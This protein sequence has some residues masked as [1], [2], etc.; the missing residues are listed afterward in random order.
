MI[1]FVFPISLFIV[2]IY[3]YSLRIP[4]TL[5]EKVTT[6]LTSSRMILRG[7]GQT[8]RARL[9]RRVDI[10]AARDISPATARE[11]SARARDRDRDPFEGRTSS[12]A[13]VRGIAGSGERAQNLGANLV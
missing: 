3:S 8:G 9:A 13:L 12:G 4:R 2:T 1:L 7:V 6:L 5:S 10:A 11:P